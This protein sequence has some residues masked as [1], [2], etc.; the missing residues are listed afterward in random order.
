[1]EYN[2]ENLFDMVDNGTEYPE[3]K[4]GAYNWT[5]STVQT[6]L[7]NIA[8]VIAEINAHIAVLVEIENENAVKE[9]L[10]AL[11]KKK[12]E[13]PYYALGDQPNRT[14]TIPVILSRFP[15]FNTQW[16]GVA[17]FVDGDTVFSRNI[18]ETDVFLGQDT[19]KVFACHWPSKIEPESRRVG[20]AKVLKERLDRIPRSTPYLI[21]GDFN[22]NYDECSSFHTLGLDDSY[23]VTGINHVLGTLRAQSGA[24]IEYM[25]KRHVCRSEKI[26]HFD[27]WL[28]LPEDKRMSEVFKRQKNTPD[29]ILLSPGLFDSLGF[30]YVDYSFRVFAWNGRLLFN[31]SPYRW[32]MRF[33]GQRKYHRGQGYSDHLPILVRLCRGPFHF[34]SLAP[35]TVTRANRKNPIGTVGFETGHEGWVS[36]SPYISLRRDTNNVRSGLYCL[37][38]S[39]GETKQN[40]CAARSILSL[41]MK[42]DSLRHFCSMNIR[43]HG[44]L[45]LRMRAPRNKKWTYFNGADFKLAKGAKYTEYDLP[46]WISVRF[47][48]L[49]ESSVIREIEIEIRIKKET[50]MELW[51]DD[52]S[53]R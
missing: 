7:D 15:L 45:T 28:D 47:P 43:G 38:I 23:G 39:G 40:G 13:Y 44:T 32:Q 22:E 6:K 35:D 31:G 11:R 12:C 21:A 42:D 34:D 49:F 50:S 3:Y 41:N 27:P 17:A 29:H 25:T 18:L 5:L 19:L 8:S 26:R 36:C 30:S 24:S 1:M 37:K 46:D 51:I 16:H 4:P 48:L 20:A 10:S 2:V 52:I 53:I 14:I 9:L 33:N